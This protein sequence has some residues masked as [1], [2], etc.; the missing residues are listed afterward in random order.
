MHREESLVL[1]FMKIVWADDFEKR[2]QHAITFRNQWE[3]LIKEKL[4][5]NRSELPKFQE[6]ILTKSEERCW[7]A[8]IQDELHDIE[9][10]R[11][12][13]ARQVI[14]DAGL[15]HLLDESISHG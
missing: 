13:Q 14:I 4:L 12:T 15:A 2:S 5:F 7:E 8:Q 3:D 6:A 9:I 10:E 1:L 11:Q